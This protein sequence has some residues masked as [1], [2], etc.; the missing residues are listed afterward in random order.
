MYA[1]RREKGEEDAAD[2]VVATDEASIIQWGA[3]DVFVFCARLKTSQA[4]FGS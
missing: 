3:A 2:D 4:H 1:L